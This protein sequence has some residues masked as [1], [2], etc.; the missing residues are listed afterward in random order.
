VG[1]DYYLLAMAGGEVVAAIPAFLKRS[2]YGNVLN[3]LPFWGSNGGI[4]VKTS[5]PA[6]EERSVK[7]SLL[8][9]FYELAEQLKCVLSTIIVS[10]LE[11]DKVFYERHARAEFTD[12]RIGQITILPDTPDPDKLLR[13]FESV[14]RRNIKKALKSGISCYQSNEPE[15][16]EF[17]Y[18]LHVE[19]ISTIGG[20]T[21]P[22]EFFEAVQNVLSHGSDY[23]LYI[24]EKD[25][26]PIAALL[27][28]YYN[29]VVE[30]YIPAIVKD[31]RTFQPLSLLVFEAMLNAMRRGFKYWNW[32][33]TWYIQTGV[34]DFKK[35]WGANDRPYRYYVKQHRD[36]SNIKSLGKSDILKK[37]PYYYVIPFTELE[38]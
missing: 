38:N 21:K 16:M 31:Y 27:L 25:E 35:R 18:N 32:G 12:E 13:L 36:I 11:K 24:A 4:I 20:L 30:Y 7:R 6:D 29:R 26:T 33:G 8:R 17:L 1:E 14:R 15:A 37:Y 22:P 3:S 5:L 28:F 9:S 2:E 10:P 34:Y 19:N 23:R